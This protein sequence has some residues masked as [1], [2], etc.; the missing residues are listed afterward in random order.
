MSAPS[1]LVLKCPNCGEVVPHRVLRGKIAGKD[2]IAF[3]D[4]FI[5]PRDLAAEDPMRHD[6]AAIRT[7]EDQGARGRHRRSSERA[8]P[9]KDLRP[10]P[11]SVRRHTNLSRILAMC[12]AA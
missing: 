1:A 9:P 2:E 7:L 4:D 6:L 12:S 8:G 3:E 5:L 11:T 10:W